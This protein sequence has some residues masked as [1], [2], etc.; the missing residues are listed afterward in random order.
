M[1]QGH[2][3]QQSE[4]N[5]IHLVA[6]LNHTVISVSERYCTSMRL[7]RDHETSSDSTE[8]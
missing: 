7:W 2:E 3:Q 6:K 4:I 1:S 5:G 8:V